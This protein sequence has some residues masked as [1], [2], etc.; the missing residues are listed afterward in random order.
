MQGRFLG[1][2]RYELGKDLD[3]FGWYDAMKTHSFLEHRV[4][5][6]GVEQWAQ[7]L[8]QVVQRV[9]KLEH[10]ETIEKQV[11]HGY[12]SF[13]SKVKNKSLLW[14]SEIR[15]DTIRFEHV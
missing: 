10:H 9:A 11:G 6:D 3:G 5:G 1:Q 14:E 8:V 15:M 12:A 4:E 2:P 13:K 7:S